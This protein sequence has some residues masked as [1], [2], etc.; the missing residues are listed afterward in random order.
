MH[1]RRQD[2]MTLIEIV[3]VLAIIGAVAAL[4]IPRLD[5]WFDNLRVKSAARAASDAFQLARSEAIRTGHNHVV[6]FG[7]PGTTDPDG[8]PVAKAN[9]DWVPILV[10]DDGAP[11]AANCQI[12]DGERIH[13]VE[14]EEGVSWGVSGATGAVPIDGGTGPYA[15]GS[16]FADPTNTPVPWVLFRPDGV[17]VVFTG[18]GANCGTIATTGSGKGA[19][20]VTNGHLDYAAVLSPLG[21]VRIH[22]WQAEG[23]AWSG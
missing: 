19:L 18:A 1:A 16:S 21:G 5:A 10:I 13:Y 2:G 7:P 12:E 4:S 8:N 17:P 14:A 15:S 9:G 3:V 20:Y 11:T 23:S 22:A 6:F